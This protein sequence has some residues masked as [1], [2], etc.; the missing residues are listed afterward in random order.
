MKAKII[1]KECIIVDGAECDGCGFCNICDLDPNKICDNC[2][3]CLPDSDYKAII[4]DKII[5]DKNNS[6]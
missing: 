1:V 3:N 4:I 5:M 2:M 6:N